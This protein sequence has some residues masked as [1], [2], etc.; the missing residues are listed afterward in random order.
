MGGDNPNATQLY[1]RHHLRTL[2]TLRALRRLLVDF[3]GLKLPKHVLAALAVLTAT[4]LGRYPVGASVGVGAASVDNED[5]SAR[6]A[7]TPVSQSQSVFDSVIG[8]S[9]PGPPSARGR[10]RLDD[11][12]DDNDSFLQG[13]GG[14]L[15]R[16]GGAAGA[17][18]ATTGGGEYAAVANFRCVIV[19]RVCASWLLDCC[20]GRVLTSAMCTFRFASRRHWWGRRRRR[21]ATVVVGLAVDIR[22]RWSGSAPTRAAVAAA[23]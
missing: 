21:T 3:P 14:R 9:R 13:G 17:G 18:G 4:P 11:D 22:R 23:C 7:G 8:A 16:P 1:R 2:L 5:L 12:D 19:A 10:R 15:N 6:V 20:C